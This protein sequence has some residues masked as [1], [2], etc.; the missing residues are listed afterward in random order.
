[1]L[2]KFFLTG[3]TLASITGVYS[4]DSVKVSSFK[5]S[6]S[7][8]GYYRFNFNEPKSA[9]YN[10]YTS[11]T[12]SQNSFE[13]GMASIKAEHTV[14]KVGFVADLGFGR[15]AEE[16][17]YNDTR[18]LQVIK[19]AFVTYAPSSHVK[20]TMGK[21]ATHVGYELVDA[22]GNRNYS[23]S[24]MFTNGPFFHTGLRTDFT[25]GK[26]GFMIGLANPTDYTTTTSNTKT[27][28]AQF[29]TGTNNDKLKAYLNYQGYSGAKRSMPG[30]SS[31]NQFDLVVIGTVS[32]EFSVGYN[33]TI[34]NVK[35]EDAKQTKKWWGS[36][37]YLNY[38][39]T[40]VF[41]LTW[42]NEYFG[43]QKY[44]LKTGGGGSNIFASTLSGNIKLDNFRII[45]EFRIDNAS[46]SIFTRSDGTSSKGTASFLLAAVYSF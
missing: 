1:M 3:L 5:W 36:A 10:N 31:L 14:G 19:Q 15:R 42:R 33:G 30:A 37:L 46:K 32:T 26:S 24:Y 9:S 16:F 43:D 29:S 35:D 4:Q 18:T 44:G 23:M 7:V 22:V 41:G 12:N 34:Q 40:S 13:L 17:S 2:Q 11:F 21:W 39:P 28:I 27:L 25:F 8:D 6:A 20:F 38:D 45:P